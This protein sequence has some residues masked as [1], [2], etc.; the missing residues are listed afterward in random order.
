MEVLA[1]E[2]TFT[3]LDHVRLPILV[4]CDRRDGSPSSRFLQLED[5]LDAAGTV[6]SRRSWNHVVTMYSQVLLVDITT[7]QR[8]KLTLCSPA[9]AESGASF[10]SVLLPEG[11]SLVGL[12]VGSVVRWRT[13]TGDERAAEILAVLFQPKATGDFSLQSSPGARFALRVPPLYSYSHWAALS[14]ASCDAVAVQCTQAHGET[15]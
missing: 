9:D 3:G 5:D 13:P 11:W 2:G 6:P 14:R 10:M 1:L 8:H 12:G 15:T 7:N 4:S